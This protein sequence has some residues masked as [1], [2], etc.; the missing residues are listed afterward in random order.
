M[1]RLLRVLQRYEGTSGNYDSER[2][3]W[4][5]VLTTLRHIA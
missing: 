4:L 1:S 2:F 5:P 3:K